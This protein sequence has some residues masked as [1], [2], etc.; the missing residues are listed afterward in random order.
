MNYYIN[1]ISNSIEYIEENLLNEI[2][3][4]LI[5]NK[6]HLSQYHFDRLFNIIVGISFK[7]YVN[8]RKLTVAAEQLINS[9]QSIIE[10]AFKFG[11]KYPEVFSRTFKKQF[12]ISPKEF[13]SSRIRINKVNKAE[14]VPRNL[15]NYKGRIILKPEYIK[16]K[17]IDLYGV[18]E[19]IDVYNKGFEKK[20]YDIA[21]NFLNQSSDNICLEKDILYNLIS[22]NGEGTSTYNCYFGKKILQNFNCNDADKRTI[23][24]GIYARFIYKGKMSD[25]RKTFENDLFRWIAIREVKLN[26]IGI[27]MI[28]IYDKN[29]YENMEIQILIP[30]CDTET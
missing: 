15:I 17:Q 10:I 5:S 27:G 18:L 16:M 22:C 20:L 24:E 21:K 26:P 23:T 7:Q 28:S 4:G 8:G 19:K 11:F 30:V 13:R 25:I 1:I 12:G 3:L 2:S 29:Y 14:V 9:N 6:F